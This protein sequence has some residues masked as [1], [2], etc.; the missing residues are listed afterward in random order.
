MTYNFPCLEGQSILQIVPALETGGVERGTLEIADA[1]LKAGGKPLVLS[2]GGAL[3]KPLEKLGAIH[4]QGS[5]Q[6][7]NPIEIFRNVGLIKNICQHY[8]VNLLHV[9]SRAPAWSV[10]GASR[11]LGIPFITTFHG[12][13]GYKGFFG[14]KK[15]YNEIMLKGKCVIANSSSIERHLKAVYKIPENFI[16]VV[17]RGVDIEYFNPNVITSQRLACLKKSWGL[18]HGM[19]NQPVVLLP[20]RLTRWKGSLVLLEA[21][22][23]LPHRN[24]LCLLVGSDQGRR[25][26]S[27]ELQNFIYKNDLKHVVKM[28][29]S[30][31]DMPA[32]LA[33]ADVVVSS[34][35]EP[36]AFGR[37]MIEAGS[38]EKPV[39]ASNHGGATDIITPE[40]GWLVQPN[41]PRA[42]A[43]ALENF[44]MLDRLAIKRMGQAARKRAV[45]HFSKHK[46]QVET[47]K[48]YNEIITVG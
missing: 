3:V 46:F 4:I 36:E 12:T 33:M 21:L 45:E 9:R 14:F 22:A 10:Y 7:K 27:E 41:D 24:F 42:L 23:R 18:K 35:I 34:S 17:F 6:T 37:V 25:E 40:T 26:F 38:M 16:R 32:A 29:G 31:Q 13:Y 5:V 43:T 47:L 8:G 1:I 39:V 11:A 30:C 28:V 15:K 19:L 20:G 44:F 48:V 2:S